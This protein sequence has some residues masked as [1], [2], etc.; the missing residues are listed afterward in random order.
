MEYGREKFMEYMHQ[1]MTD[2][3]KWKNL[4]E[5]VDKIYGTDSTKSTDEILKEIGELT[6]GQLGIGLYVG[7]P[8][9]NVNRKK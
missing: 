7:K 1:M 4:K 2:V 5:A 9:D 6:L 3:Y 8:S